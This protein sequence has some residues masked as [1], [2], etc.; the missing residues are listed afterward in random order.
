M[1]NPSYLK[2]ISTNLVLSI[3]CGI[4]TATAFPKFYANWLIFVALV[5]VVWATYHSKKYASFF[6]GFIAGFTFNCIGL[7]WL[8]LTLNFNIDSRL[9]T[10]AAF[11]VLQ[12]YLALYWGIWSFVLNIAIKK[13]TYPFHT[14]IFSSCFWVLLE[15]IRTYFLTGFPW[16]LLGY[17]QW[18][19]IQLIQI[20]EFTGVYG[21]S[22]LIVFVNLCFAFFIFRLPKK[23]NFFYK[24]R[25]RSQKSY[26]FVALILF[27]SILS[28]GFFREEKFKNFGEPERKAV[29]VQTN[30]DQYKKWDDTYKKEIVSKLERLSLDA[31]SLKADLV[32]FPET[33]VPNLLY[34]DSVNLE[35]AR[36]IVKTCKNL[37]IVGA[38]CAENKTLYNA[39]LAFRPDE[40]IAIHKKNHLVPF[41]EFIPLRKILSKF[42]GILNIMG[43]FERGTDKN[44]FKDKHLTVG[45]TI[46]SENFF[47]NISRIFTKN[48]AKVFANCTNDAWFF[49]TSAPYQHFVMNIFRAIEN[50]K[51]VLVSAN[52]GLSGIITTQGKIKTTAPLFQDFIIEGTF[53]QNDYKTFYV[54]FGDIFVYLCIFTMLLLLRHFKFKATSKQTLKQTLF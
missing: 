40:E 18:S 19:F 17:S 22:F 49:D 53:R 27:V 11:C 6:W 30:I 41:G 38:I 42:F 33:V 21:V 32:V 26:F 3:V 4:F 15:Y 28:L 2:K 16:N 5:P 10:T 46:C 13:F 39:L 34:L 24:K 12:I 35:W 8:M 37:A 51:D 54:K 45:G 44:I 36:N 47:P 9:E 25:L 14:I 52:T 48:G 50:R 1:K 7:Y 20:A 31:A 43:D 23:N 29:I